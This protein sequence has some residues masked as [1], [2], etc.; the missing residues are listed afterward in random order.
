MTHSDLISSFLEATAP[1]D[2]LGN[3]WGAR[4]VQAFR[5]PKGFEFGI[6]SMING[7]AAYGLLRAMLRLEGF[8]S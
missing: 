6:V 3:H 7:L 1:K 4:H 2:F 5:F 8:E